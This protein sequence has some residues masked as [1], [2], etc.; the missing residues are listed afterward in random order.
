N[1]ARCGETQAAAQKAEE[2]RKKSPKD[3]DTLLNLMRCYALCTMTVSGP[4]ARSIPAVDEAKMREEYAASAASCFE[5]AIANGSR[6]VVDIETDPDIDAIR[7]TPAFERALH[8][9][10]E[11]ADPAA[12]KA[13]ASALTPK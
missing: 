5:Q 12:K 7:K 4:D 3:V 2:I 8:K 13:T 1:L 11:S 9:L 6:N 10:G